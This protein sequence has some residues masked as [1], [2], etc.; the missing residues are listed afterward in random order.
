MCILQ[1]LQGRRMTQEPTDMLDGY[2]KWATQHVQCIASLT[3]QNI[4][5]SMDTGLQYHA[6]VE[7]REN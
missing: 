1:L 2:L 4:H 6:D 5:G 7:G 3:S